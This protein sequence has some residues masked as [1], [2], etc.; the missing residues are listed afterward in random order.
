MDSDAMLLNI[1][2]LMNGECKPIGFDSIPS[3]SLGVQFMA[4]ALN[5]NQAL[6]QFWVDL[7]YNGSL[8]RFRWRYK[9]TF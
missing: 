9:Q 7:N 3:R 6:D 4:D 5:E 2:D 1:L 8:T